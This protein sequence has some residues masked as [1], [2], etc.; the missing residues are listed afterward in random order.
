MFDLLAGTVRSAIQE[1]QFRPDVDPDQFAY[2]FWG[3]MLAFHSASRL[4]R[5][6]KARQRARAAFDSL[7]QRARV[8]PATVA[9]RHRT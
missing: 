3:A 4:M 2:E 6:P 9:P 7:V 8:V 1:G 5:D